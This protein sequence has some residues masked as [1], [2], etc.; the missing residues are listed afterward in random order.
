MSC[1]LTFLS[2]CVELA[3]R[4]GTPDSVLHLPRT[5]W[6][7]RGYFVVA[8]HFE[9][10]DSVIWAPTA[11]TGAPQARPTHSEKRSVDSLHVLSHKRGL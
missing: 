3:A 5:T 6:G 2:E 8:V 9:I 10:R 1:Q 11:D 7:S 4:H